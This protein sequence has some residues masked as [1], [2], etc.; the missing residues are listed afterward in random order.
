MGHRIEVFV[1]GCPLC[2]EA[3]DIVRAAMCPEC[4]LEVYNILEKPEY[5]KKARQYGIRAVPAIVIDGEKRFE[6][7]PSL[8]EVKRALGTI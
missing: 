4:R 6:G 3:V 5:M 2:R 1:S 8:E 7:V